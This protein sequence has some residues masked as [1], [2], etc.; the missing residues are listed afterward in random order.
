MGSGARANCSRSS[1]GGWSALMSSVRWRR[2]YPKYDEGSKCS[3]KRAEQSTK[4]GSQ[5]GAPKSVALKYNNNEH[6]T[7]KAW[8]YI[9]QRAGSNLPDVA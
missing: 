3:R 2:S 5:R 7:G 1:G 6:P 8:R 9:E 4:R